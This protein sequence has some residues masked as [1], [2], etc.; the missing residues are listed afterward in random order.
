MKLGGWTGRVF[1]WQSVT[2]K[3]ISRYIQLFCDANS[4]LTFTSIYSKIQEKYSI[5][6]CWRLPLLTSTLFCPYLLALG[7]YRNC[8]RGVVAV[9]SP[10]A[11]RRWTTKQPIAPGSILSSLWLVNLSSHILSVGWVYHTVFPTTSG[12]EEWL[13]SLL[14]PRKLT[15][16]ASLIYYVMIK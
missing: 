6:G 11:S 9:N 3:R 12:L 4:V 7:N 16:R 13:F 5:Q 10:D 14:H 1:H 2:S 8:Q 15:N